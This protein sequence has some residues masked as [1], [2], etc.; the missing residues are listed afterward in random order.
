L[1]RWGW[2]E[3]PSARRVRIPPP[4]RIDADAQRALQ[5]DR[6][7]DAS[8]PV[9][10][11]DASAILSTLI[12]D[13]HS[14]RATATA[15]RRGT[16]L[17]ATLAY[18]EVAAVIARL[19]RLGELPTVLADASRELLRDGPWRRLHLQPD[20]ASIDGLAVQSPLRRADLWHLATAVT[21]SRELPEVRV[22]T[23]DGR[24]A[25]ASAALGLA[26]LN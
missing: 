5:E 4:L 23:L 10:Y 24:L 15:R 8:I 9:V 18:A 17:V 16:H 2:I 14:A 12:N 21:V 11:W 22:I 26:L 13:L 19:E 25:A 7:P 6:V 1:E 20:W 3:P